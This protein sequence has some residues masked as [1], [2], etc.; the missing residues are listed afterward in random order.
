VFGALAADAVYVTLGPRGKDVI[1]EMLSAK[2]LAE[3]TPL[4]L[5]RISGKRTLSLYK[6]LGAAPEAL[7]YLEK[8]TTAEQSSV[9]GVHVSGG[10]KLALRVD[11]GLPALWIVTPK[12]SK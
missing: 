6:L 2:P 5:A 9:L 1:T 7:A 12:P 11:V 3:P 10:D 4:V 8:L